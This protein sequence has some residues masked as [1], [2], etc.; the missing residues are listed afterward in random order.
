[1]RK[2]YLI[3][4]NKHI[5]EN[6]LVD[7][8]NSILKNLYQRGYF[9]YLDEVLIRRKKYYF[10]FGGNTTQFKILIKEIKDYLHIQKHYSIS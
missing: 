4:F 7:F 3:K 2:F 1:M 10:I 5:E 6:F 9:F 8:I